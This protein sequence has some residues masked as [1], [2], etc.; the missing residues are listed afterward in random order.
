MAESPRTTQGDRERTLVA[1]VRKSVAEWY[2]DSTPMSDLK[3][4]LEVYDGRSTLCCPECKTALSE[5][6]A[7]VTGLCPSHGVVVTVKA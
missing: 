5:V 7:T 4:A 6:R 2:S 1:Q 3:D